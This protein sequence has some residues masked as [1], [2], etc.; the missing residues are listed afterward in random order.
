MRRRDGGIDDELQAHLNMAIRDRIE[1]GEDS[2]EAEAGARREFG[3]LAIHKEETRGVWIAPWLESVAQDLKYAIRGLRRSPGFTAVAIA[4]LALGIGAN[5]ALFTIANAIMLKMLPVRNP[6]E[7]VEL[8]QQYPGE[9]RG[10]GYWSVPSYEHFRDNNHVFSALAGYSRDNRA[11]VA[12]GGGESVFMAADHVTPNF[13]E[14]VGIAPAFGRLIGSGDNGQTAVVSW[15]LYQRNPS[16]LGRQVS[17]DKRSVTVVGVAP[18]AFTGFLIGSPTDLWVSRKPGL[19]SRMTVMGR[20]APHATL[21]QA[22]AEFQSLGRF[23]VEELTRTRSDPQW[24]RM[25][26]FV[27]FAGNGSGN[28]RGRFGTPI[29]IVMSISGLLLLIACVNLAS[30]L[31]ARGASRQ[32]E[33]FIRA[34]LG[35]SQTRLIRQVLTESMLLSG[36]G[37]AVGFC[38]SYSAVS[39]VTAIMANGRVHERVVLNLTPDADSLLFTAAVAIVTGL[40]FGLAPALTAKPSRRIHRFGDALVAAQIAIAVV[41]LAAATLHTGYV[42]DLRNVNLGFHRDN[43]ILMQLDGSRGHEKQRAVELIRRLEALPGVRSASIGGMSPIQGAGASRMVLADGFTED[44]DAR[45]YTSLN[46]VTPRYFE[47]LGIPLLA[48]RDFRFDDEGRQR[49]AV[50]SQSFARH[51]FP[52]RNAIGGHV[53]FEGR[54]TVYEIVGVVG[55]AKYLELKEAPPRT[56]YM[57]TLQDPNIVSQYVIRTAIAPGAIVNEVRRSAKEVAPDARIERVTTLTDQLDA[58]I[59]PERLVTQLANLFG[60]L[61]G[62]IAAIGVYGLLAFTVARR[63]SEIGLRMAVGAT[64]GDVLAMI[65]RQALLIT[66]TG[67]TLG[68][69][70]ASQIPGLPASVAVPASIAVAAML[71]VALVAAY[72]PARRAA[73]IEPVQALRHE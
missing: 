22:H 59:V 47:S 55:D 62:L 60:A 26:F 20:L 35:A 34:G 42:A 49:V 32:R 14:V 18:A 48:G 50:V 13:L 38:I 72:V 12:I 58:S 16:I 28:L 21:E 39:A 69:A 27:D 54:T 65:L 37:A 36:A 33:M 44:P 43:V 63:T 23:T 46:W 73:S 68:A 17:I 11:Q 24:K 52:S 57:N 64:P 45:R 10:N 41:L 70:V 7:I 25:K 31:L 67:V 53:R 15:S 66:V 19:D 1:R 4:S 3:N 56:M 71:V 51:Y 9:P 29:A 6:H 2:R 5:T 61:G 40:L 30:L 8:L